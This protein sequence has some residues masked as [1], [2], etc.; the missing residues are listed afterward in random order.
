MVPWGVEVLDGDMEVL[1]GDN[2]QL[3]FLSAQESAQGWQK[4]SRQ[5]C[6]HSLSRGVSVQHAPPFPGSSKINSVPVSCWREEV[7]PS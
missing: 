5:L 1:E 2:E 3:L 6:T 7:A 4:S